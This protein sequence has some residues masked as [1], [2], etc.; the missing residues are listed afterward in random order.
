MA[1]DSTVRVKKLTRQ[2]AP[3]RFRDHFAKCRVEVLE[4]LNGTQAVIWKRR[5]IGRYDRN[6]QANEIKDPVDQARRS[7]YRLLAACRR[8]RQ[9]TRRKW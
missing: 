8:D 7:H 1:N 9:E 6:G 4:Y 3:S 2:I 5:V